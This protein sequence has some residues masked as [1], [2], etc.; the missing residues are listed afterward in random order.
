MDIKILRSKKAFEKLVTISLVIGIIIVSG[1][2]AFFIVNRE[3]GYVGF[4]L[5]NSNKLA[6]D[7]P[8]DAKINENIEFYVTVENQLE[9]DFT[10]FLRILKGN[11]N[12]LMSPEGSSN[13]EMVFRT[14]NYHLEHNQSWISEKLFVS[15]S[16]SG[17]NQTIIVELWQFMEQ[18]DENFYAL[19]FLK[20]HI[21][22]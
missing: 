5:L 11:N 3:P 2:I 14:S 13:T 9:K 7:Y 19:L 12:T 20:L 8:T 16:T 17:Y 1:F 10:F 4:G 18:L 6:E 15:F 21:Y 22:D